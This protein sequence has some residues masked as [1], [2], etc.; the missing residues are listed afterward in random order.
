MNARGLSKLY[1]AGITS[2][3]MLWHAID[4]AT[5]SARNAPR[6]T[7]SRRYRRWRVVAIRAAVL[8]PFLILIAR[9]V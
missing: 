7:R 5:L 1:S 2:P 4:H 8:T 9:Y 6:L 3:D